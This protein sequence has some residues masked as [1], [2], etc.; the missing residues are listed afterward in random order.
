MTPL[1]KDLF[2]HVDH[3]NK[4]SSDETAGKSVV[5]QIDAAMEI[6]DVHDHGHVQKTGQYAIGRS[7]IT[8]DRRQ[9]CSEESADQC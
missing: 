2:D 6:T 4:R 8:G 3:R 9:G 1:L 7:V 5:I